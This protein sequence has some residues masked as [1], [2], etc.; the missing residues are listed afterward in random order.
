VGRGSGGQPRFTASVDGIS[1]LRG[2][3]DLGCQQALQHPGADI[4]KTTEHVGW[5]LQEQ[6]WFG[7]EFSSL[8]PWEY[9]NSTIQ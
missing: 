6:S 5:S 9:K 1:G 8:K 7:I 3:A 2:N 4:E